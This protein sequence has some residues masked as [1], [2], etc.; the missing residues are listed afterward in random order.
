VTA[1]G[2]VRM[3]Y[4]CD[5]RRR[6]LLGSKR[7]YQPA[8][9]FAPFHNLSFCESR[10]KMLLAHVAVPESSEYRPAPRSVRAARGLIV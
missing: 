10:K 6:P 8:A 2:V 1:G 3:W 7:S 5:I 9:S 4:F